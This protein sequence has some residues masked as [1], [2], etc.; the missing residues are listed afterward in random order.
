MS[1][2]DEVP[3][4]R[5]WCESVIA[6]IDDFKLSEA[7]AFASLTTAVL[8][9]TGVDRQREAFTPE[10][11]EKSAAEIPQVP[12]G[13][14][15]GWQHDPLVQTTG[16]IVAA[17]VF[18]APQSKMYFTAAVIG[19]YDPA[20]AKSFRSV[21]VDAVPSPSANISM[22]AVDEREEV[23][24]SFNP[25]E[26]QPEIIA[27]LLAGAP[28]IISKR[29]VR[30]IRK[31]AD[32][33]T[34]VGVLVSVPLLA[35]LGGFGKSFGE[36]LGKRLGEKSAD[37]VL[38]WFGEV[39]SRIAA[40]VNKRVLFVFY[41]EDGECLIE[42]VI[43]SRDTKVLCE[44]TRTA[45]AAAASAAL[46]KERLRDLNVVKLV[47]SFDVDTW[48]WLPLHATS[49]KGVVVCDR[50]YLVSIEPGMGISGGGIVPDE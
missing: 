22:P 43:D 18:Y 37:A 13:A 3:E 34:I 2:I 11:L 14:W 1:L 33:L 38:S 12:W 35:F 28:S 36:G 6:L 50:P 19:S 32:P 40:V 31:A 49:K 30:A 27:E 44:A 4:A 23:R 24:V 8:N 42:F 39:F 17:R 16:R 48:R 9:S 41:S 29:P 47:Y 26:V 15:M 45:G 7:E 46:L 5:E 21:G 25:H 20:R 10:A